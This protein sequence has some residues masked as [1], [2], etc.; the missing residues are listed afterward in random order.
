MPIGNGEIGLNVWTETNGDVVFYLAR[1]DAWD[2]N[3]RL[4]KLGRIRLTASPP[5][6]TPGEK[7]TQTLNFREGVI[8]IQGGEGPQAVTL[9][10]AADVNPPVVRIGM[11][12]GTPCQLKATL[13]IWRKERRWVEEAGMTCWYMAGSFEA[14]G[15]KVYSSGLVMGEGF[16]TG[17]PTGIES[18]A[19]RNFNLLV[20]L[21][22]AQTDTAAAWE[23]EA[24][25]A[26]ERAR[27]DQN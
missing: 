20:S 1:T 11:N 17:S 10:I 19:E 15:K 21:S 27:Q 3:G 8:Q 4:L 25:A 26:L 9:E 18:K 2:E 6:V 24:F 12:S 7:V 14:L 13:K 5:L 16:Q 22:T 23:S